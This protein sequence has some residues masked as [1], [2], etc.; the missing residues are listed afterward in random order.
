MPLTEST[1]A[2]SSAPTLVLV[3]GGTV[4]SRMWDAVLPH[5]DAPALAVDLPGRRYRPYDLSLVTNRT[6]IE[7][8]RDDIVANDPDAVVLVGHSSGGYVIPGVAAL[9]PER[10]RHLVFVAATVPAD[11]RK[12]VP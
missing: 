11:A 12:P 7:A 2:P 10:V 4:D 6:W 5:L 3:H 8:V 9:L 1:P